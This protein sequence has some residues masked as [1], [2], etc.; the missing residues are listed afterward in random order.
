MVRT[1]PMPDGDLKVSEFT[2]L[3]R[4]LPPYEVIRV[5]PSEDEV[6]LW[7]TESAEGLTLRGVTARYFKTWWGLHS[8]TRR[9]PERKPV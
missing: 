5:H 8:A 2:A 4:T 3:W 9:P 7:L 6:R 1:I